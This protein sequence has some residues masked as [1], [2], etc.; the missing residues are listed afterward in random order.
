MW[1]DMCIVSF[2]TMTSMW[3]TIGSISCV[4]LSSL[5]GYVVLIVL[6]EDQ[7]YIWWK[8]MRINLNECMVSFSM[9]PL[10]ATFVSHLR[11]TSRLKHSRRQSPL[12]LRINLLLLSRTMFIIK[13]VSIILVMQE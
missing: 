13:L 4:H 9:Q 6:R 10:S 7:R 1:V 5:L 11:G 8:S 3:G 12:L 2:V